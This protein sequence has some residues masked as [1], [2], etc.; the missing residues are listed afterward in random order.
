MNKKYLL[1]KK[2]INIENEIQSW[3]DTSRC[4]MWIIHWDN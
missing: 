2:I 1:L 3:G 4:T